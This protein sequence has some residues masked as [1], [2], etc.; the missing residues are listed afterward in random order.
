ME[1]KPKLKK[2]KMGSPLLPPAR[3]FHLQVNLF[4]AL[5]KAR[6]IALSR[7]AH[8]FFEPLMSEGMGEGKEQRE[9][10]CVCM[11]VCVCV[12]MREVERYIVR[13]ATIRIIVHDGDRDLGNSTQQ[14]TTT[15]TK[16]AWPTL[17]HFG[18]SI[19]WYPSMVRQRTAGLRQLLTNGE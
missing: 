13:D 4:V 1:I 18:T 19:A 11:R 2:E 16:G 17:A 5:E 3:T 6:C 15:L 10:E 7:F 12:C 8:T 14:C 9:R